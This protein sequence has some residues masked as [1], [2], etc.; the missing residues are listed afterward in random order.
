MRI[1]IITPSVTVSDVKLLFEIGVAGVVHNTVSADNF[2]DYINKI[3]NGNKVL[4]PQFRDL[5]IEYFCHSR[6][7]TEQE[8][9]KNSSFPNDIL[10]VKSLL[11]EKKKYYVIFAMVKVPEK[12]QKNCF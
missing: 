2:T 12:F 4:A 1:L 6:P 8:N 9:G 7:K 10:F 5:I 3:L 11:K